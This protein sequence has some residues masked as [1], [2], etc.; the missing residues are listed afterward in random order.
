MSESSAIHAGTDS[1]KKRKA[2]EEA[3][4]TPIIKAMPTEI[5][6]KRRAA[7]DGPSRSFGV[8][9]KRGR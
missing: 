4:L 5:A 2:M 7:Y 1:V 8:G 3:G 9:Q 6:K